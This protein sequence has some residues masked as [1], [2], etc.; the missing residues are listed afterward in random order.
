MN[1]TPAIAPR[2]RSCVGEK[3]TGPLPAMRLRVIAIAPVIDCETDGAP[4]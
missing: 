2:P 4:A 1:T 3:R